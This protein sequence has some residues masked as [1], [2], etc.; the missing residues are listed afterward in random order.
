MATYT[1]SVTKTQYAS[2]GWTYINFD[3]ITPAAGEE[4]V[5]W[6]AEQSSGSG[7][8]ELRD[9][10]WTPRTWGSWYTNPGQINCSG[11]F[12][13]P[14][15]Q[16]RFNASSGTL[17]VT[18]TLTLEFTQTTFTVTVTAGSGGTANT[19]KANAQAGETVTITCSPGTGYSANVPTATGVTFAGAGTN[20]WQ[21][22]MPA[23]DTAVSCTFAKIDYTV[24]AAASPAGAGT[25]SVSPSTANYGDT[26]SISQTPASDYV[27]DG[28]IINPP[29]TIS[30]GQ[31]TMPA[32]NVTL[33]A[34]YKKKSTCTLS[35]SSMTGGQNVIMNITPGSI[36]YTHKYQLSFGTNMETAE[37]TVAAGVT[38]VTIAVPE[39]WSNYI[40]A[41]ETKTGGT[42]T[43][44]CYDGTTLVA[45][46]TV[47]GLTYNV[48]AS[49][50][51]SIGTITTSIVTTVGGV[52]YFSPGAYYVQNK[53]AVRVQA[54]AGGALGSTVASMEVILGGYTD[55]DHKTTVSAAS[56]DYTSGLLTNAGACSI[57]VKATDSRG[58]TG[59]AVAIITVQPYNR[60]A[61]SLRVWRVDANGDEDPMGSYAD[62]ELTKSY[63]Q[64][65]TNA[66]TWSITSQGSSVSSPADTGH[67]LPGSRQTFADTTEYTITLTM[68]DSFNETV[69]IQVKLP[70][71]QFMIYVNPNGDRI[72]FMKAANESLSKNGKNGTIEFSDDHQIYIGSVTL[73]QYILN[74]VNGI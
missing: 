30:G 8:I 7:Q 6:K 65:G 26:V 45:T 33:T 19:N 55:N 72:A 56:V 63:T 68:T 15:I 23:A 28:W 46:Y 36:S 57:T 39:S 12:S 60:P 66:L 3:A 59:F 43:L 49:A 31:F 18:Y 11:G 22:T 67:L 21:F 38:S 34:N 64:I 17:N 47:T 50:V 73:E 37:V 4:F 54:S 69:Q 62:Y 2:E 24:T 9:L 5:R 27:F 71:A 58:R 35:T 16:A 10:N 20:I 48:P 61:G 42:L 29:T 52:T 40:P 13:A 51:P 41:A 32:S 14:K 1:K 25:I 70:S 74:V 53:S 44:K